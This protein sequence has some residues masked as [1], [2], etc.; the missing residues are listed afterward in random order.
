MIQRRT[1]A[2][3]R[4][5][6]TW[7]VPAPAPR[8][9][10]AKGVLGALLAFTSPPWA[11]SSPTTAPTPCA[12]VHADPAFADALPAPICADMLGRDECGVPEIRA[13]CNLTCT[14]CTAA[15]VV[16]P[17]RAPTSHQAAVPY[18]PGSATVTEI[19]TNDGTV[20]VATSTMH[21]VCQNELPADATMIE[22]VMGQVHDFFRP[23]ADL[24]VCTMLQSEFSHEF[25]NGTDWVVPVHL[26]G[27]G[28]SASTWPR[29]NVDGDARDRLSFWGPRPG[30]VY[31]GCNGCVGGCCS[32][33]YSGPSTG[34]GQPF[35]INAIS[36][37]PGPTVSPTPCA[38]VH[39]DPSFVDALPAPICADVLAQDECV[40]PAIR[41]RCNFTCTGCT[42]ASVIPPTVA[43][44][45]HQAAVPLFSGPVAVTE[46]Y[47]N[48]G[49]V[50]VTVSVVQGI[51][52]WLPTGTTVIEVVMGTV[53]DFFRP[54]PGYTVCQ[55]LLDRER[56]EV[57]TGAEWVVP[58]YSVAYLGG[59]DEYWPLNNAANDARGRLS[60]WGL[61]IDGGPNGAPEYRG[62]CCSSSYSVGHEG[63]NRSYT[64]NAVV[65]A[66]APTASPIACADVRIQPSFADALPAPICA[67]ILGRD[68]CWVP[69]IR[70]R[71]NLTCTGCTAAPTVSPTCG[72]SQYLHPPPTPPT[73]LYGCPSSTVCGGDGFIQIGEW[74][75]GNV[76]GVHFSVSN[77]VRRVTAVVFTSAG[78][79]LD[80]PR[81]DYGLWDRPTTRITNVVA[82]DRY[83]EFSGVWRLGDVDLNHFSIQHISRK[84]AMIWRRDGERHPSN[85]ARSDWGTFRR[86]GDERD[87]HSVGYGSGFVQIGSWRLGDVGE[88]KLSVW[89]TST[90]TTSV[91]Y[92]A[93]GGVAVIT[94]QRHN[95]SAQ[96]RNPVTGSLTGLPGY[97][98][99]SD[100]ACTPCR[101]S[102]PPGFTLEFVCNQTHD[103]GC[104]EDTPADPDSNAA[105][106]GDP[107]GDSG[108]HVILNVVLAVALV[109]TVLLFIFRERAKRHHRVQLPSGGLTS[110][111]TFNTVEYPTAARR[112]GSMSAE[113]DGGTG[114]SPEYAQINYAV[115]GVPGHPGSEE[116]AAGYVVGSIQGHD[117]LTPIY[118]EPFPIGTN[119]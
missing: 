109:G 87:G 15:P 92:S 112:R 6:A 84:V 58:T 105:G 78:R 85:G 12:D 63:W 41:A 34:W 60:V 33:A 59:S 113:Q 111:P 57:Y 19:Y 25:Y 75:V 70:A 4:R 102:C 51:C 26:N 80:G 24:T 42:A 21:A 93:S 49:T 7:G 8:A 69:E 99:R 66:P 90:N 48:N 61:G 65:T 44:T 97:L 9:F 36:A 104:R 71:C 20:E 82:G 89:A 67:S 47:S 62:G 100:G 31:N 95:A 56:H 32:T 50:L 17:T 18:A 91:L 13:Q 3:S 64:M 94:N 79:Y 103:T 37:T 53:H 117:G 11:T 72:L 115:A 40:I 74:R 52:A 29:V 43:P 10:L 38:D 101:E 2:P 30:N 106:A 110:N 76:D 81:S 116:D 108:A 55:M 46:V 16:P 86:R 119:A 83:L 96:N 118:Q 54:I 39:T 28:G 107:D 98:D 68:E 27:F 14:G 114:A 45:S 5:G 22:V 1:V 77:R 23:V 73:G 35:S 88:G